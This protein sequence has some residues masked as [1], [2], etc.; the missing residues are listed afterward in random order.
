MTDESVIRGAIIKWLHE[1]Q[2]GVRYAQDG[3]WE[4]WRVGGRKKP[5]CFWRDRLQVGVCNIF[6]GDCDL[7]VKL[8]ELIG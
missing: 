3:W 1:Q 4:V 8:E 7:Y 5:M 6:Y 2:F